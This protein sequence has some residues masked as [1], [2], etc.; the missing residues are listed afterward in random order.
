MKTHSRLASPYLLLL[1]DASRL[2][3]VHV[4]G[5][6]DGLIEDSLAIGKLDG[7]CFGDLGT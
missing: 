4:D 2:F 7:G 5:N 1:E 6:R 3:V